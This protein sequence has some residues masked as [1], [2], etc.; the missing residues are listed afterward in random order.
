MGVV[1]VQ[2]VKN[3]VDIFFPAKPIYLDGNWPY[4]PAV[5]WTFWT[6]LGRHS[7]T[8]WPNSVKFCRTTRKSF[9]LICTD[10]NELF[11]HQVT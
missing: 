1:C 2:T 4:W 10:N 7:A 3:R 11:F 5:S 9:P 6:Y 8:Y